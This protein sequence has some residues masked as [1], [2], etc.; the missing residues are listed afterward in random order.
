MTIAIVPPQL[1][2]TVIELLFGKG[3]ALGLATLKLLQAM[4]GGVKST[5]LIVCIPVDIFPEASVAF[6]VRLMVYWFTQF[7]FVIK[8]VYVIVILAEGVQLSVA[9]ACPVFA[10]MGFM[11]H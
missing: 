2:V 11:L 7:P 10:G 1:S 8:L 5:T 6:H 3:I 9:V 4:T